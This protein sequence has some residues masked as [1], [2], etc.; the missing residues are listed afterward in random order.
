[1]KAILYAVAALLC[2]GPLA[3]QQPPPTDSTHVLHVRLTGLVLMNAF[4]NSMSVDNSDDPQ[5]AIPPG[6]PTGLPEPHG[7]ATARQ[8]EL[9]LHAT[10]PRLA[11]AAFTGE[12]TVDFFGGQEPSMGGRTWPLL[13]LRRIRAQ[14][15]WP[16]SWV[17]FG[18]D[19][20]P[21]AAVNPSSL[22]A[23]GLP[24][25]SESGNLWL[26]IPQVR[27]GAETPG[28]V[29]LG[30]EGAVLAPTTGDSQGTFLTQPNRA[31]RSRRPSLEARLLL[32][33]DERGSSG[34]LSLGGHYGWIVRARDTLV[35]SRALAA[36]ARFTITRYV[37]VRGE[38]FTGQALAGLGGGGVGQN[39]GPTGQ[40]VRTLGGWFQI[41]LHPSPTLELGG[42]YGRDDPNDADIDPTTGVL[43]NLSF[44]G[45]IQWR[46]APLVLGVEF[47]QIQTMYHGPLWA[48]TIN[49]FNVAAGFAF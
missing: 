2:T 14:L 21:I 4:Y 13:R 8:S 48:L 29:R 22:A 44:E 46:P 25:F 32:S 6:P 19:G 3:A 43:R 49:H 35:I 9:T 24:E 5:I 11:H 31:E 30:V 47:R 17:M 12:I 45:H 20:P 34:R 33:W 23:R 1:M 10:G 27:A 15:R 18:Q 42:G 40:P 41:N 38:I 28:R 37:E 7:G 16:H 39:L 26:W 36:S